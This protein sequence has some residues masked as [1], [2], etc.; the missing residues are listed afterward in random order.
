[1]CEYPKQCRKNIKRLSKLINQSTDIVYGMMLMTALLM[2]L[3]PTDEE[4]FDMIL[5][6]YGL[7]ETT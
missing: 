7:E 4:V 2:D 5:K 3:N 1:M 6:D